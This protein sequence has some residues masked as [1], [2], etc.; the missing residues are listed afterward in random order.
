MKIKVTVVYEMEESDAQH[1]IEGVKTR[2]VMGGTGA[3]V[4]CYQGDAMEE[5]DDVQQRLADAERRNAE[6]TELLD[7]HQWQ[8]KPYDDH[9]HIDA[10]YFCIQCSNAKASG[11]ATECLVAAALNKPE[12]AKS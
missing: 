12:K 1:L 3:I 2:Q 7:E 10:G 11:H 6:L 4:A 8:W 9:Y 5:R